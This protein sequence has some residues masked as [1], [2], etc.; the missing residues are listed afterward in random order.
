MGTA[1]SCHECKCNS[2]PPTPTGAPATVRAFAFS[3]GAEEEVCN[4]EPRC[5]TPVLTQTPAIACKDQ[6]SF[7][8]KSGICEMA[9]KGIDAER[10]LSFRLQ[11][12]ASRLGLQ[13]AETTQ[14]GRKLAKLLVVANV[15]ATSAFARTAD[16]KLGVTA[17]DVIVEADGRRGT[18]AAVHDMLQQAVDCSGHRQITLVVRP[19]PS[20]FYV[21]MLRDGPYWNTLGITLMIDKTNPGSALIQSVRDEGLVPDWNRTHGSLRIC[22]GDLITQVNDLFEE[23]A[24]AM[25]KEIQEGRRGSQ[26]RFHLRTS[27]A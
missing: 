23:D 14:G 17:G 19:R 9:R 5:K 11:P 21:E 20:S 16:G 22:A 10:S 27:I 15:E 18:A 2:Q 24:T 12:G 8:Q 26:L 1:P 7:F 13:L 6:H 3:E 4:L 25:C